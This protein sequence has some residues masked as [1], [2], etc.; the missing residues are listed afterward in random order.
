MAVTSCLALVPIAAGPPLSV[1]LALLAL[2]GYGTAFQIT[3]NAR[4]V[5]EVP[6]THRARAF[7]VAVAAMMAGNGLATAASGAVSDLLGSPSLAIGLCGVAGVV[8]LLPLTRNPLTPPDA[9]S[10]PSAGTPSAAGRTAP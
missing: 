4:F 2:S 10:P 6:D 9:G 5:T 3:L 7:G 1:L 8:C